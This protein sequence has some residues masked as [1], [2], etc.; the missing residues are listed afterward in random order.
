M[1]AEERTVCTLH[2]SGRY[3][4]AC[5]PV[6]TLTSPA[7]SAHTLLTL[8]SSPFSFCSSAP[9]RIRLLCVLV[10]VVVTYRHLCRVC[11]DVKITSLT[12]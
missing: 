5:V 3:K 11:C 2:T 7:L 10:T 4:P 1:G 9:H 6:I 12:N 8:C